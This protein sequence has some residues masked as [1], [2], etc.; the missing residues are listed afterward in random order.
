MSGA[1]KAVGSSTP[2]SYEG[3]SS[4]LNSQFSSLAAHEV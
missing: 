2:T 1:L 3:L 4:V